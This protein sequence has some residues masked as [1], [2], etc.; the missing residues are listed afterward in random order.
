MPRFKNLM[1]R[2]KV[3]CTTL[4][5]VAK[6]AEVAGPHKRIADGLRDV[7]A[8]RTVI[9]AQTWLDAERWLDDGGDVR[10]GALDLRR[11]ETSS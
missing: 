5:P 2:F 8:G 11:L 6:L 3:A 9:D 10:T 4:E 7:F 1:P